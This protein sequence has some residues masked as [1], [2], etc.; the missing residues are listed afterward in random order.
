VSRFYVQRDVKSARFRI[1]FEN[2]DALTMKVMGLKHTYLCR[3]GKYGKL[4][5]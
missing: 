5:N 4:C 2:V 3:L 1:I